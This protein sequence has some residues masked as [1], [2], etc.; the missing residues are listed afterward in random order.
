MAGPRGP[1]VER[2]SYFLLLLRHLPAFFRALMAGRGTLLTM[3]L[4]MFGAFIAARLTNLS[5]H[6]AELRGIL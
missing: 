1:A 4:F 5:A 3:L 6:R 2:D